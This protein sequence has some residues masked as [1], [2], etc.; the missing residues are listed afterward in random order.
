MSA[1]SRIWPF[2]IVAKAILVARLRGE[3]AYQTGRK[4]HENPGFGSLLGE[5]EAFVGL[6]D[7]DADKRQLSIA[8]VLKS[9]PHTGE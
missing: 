8:I 2:G 3:G 1:D 4:R 6:L 7:Q 9:W 5:Y